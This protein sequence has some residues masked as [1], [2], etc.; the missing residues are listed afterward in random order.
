M[1]VERVTYGF[2]AA[3]AQGI[4]FDI[5]SNPAEARCD[6]PQAVLGH[7]AERNITNA[8]RIH[9]TLAGIGIETGSSVAV[10]AGA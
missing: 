9:A 7:E 5:H 3:G 4:E 8:R 6:G 1:L 10:A 2:I